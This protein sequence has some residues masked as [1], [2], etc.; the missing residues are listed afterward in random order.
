MIKKNL[1]NCLKEIFRK[2]RIPKNIKNLQFGS[3]DSWDSLAHLN[4]LLLIEKKFKIKFSLEEMYKIKTVKEIIYAI[5]KY[6]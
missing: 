3:F 1:L 6:K 4:L 5:N 2:E